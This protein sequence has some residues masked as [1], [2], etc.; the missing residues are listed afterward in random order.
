MPEKLVVRDWQKIRSWLEP[1]IQSGQVRLISLDV[2]D[3]LLARCVEPP[4]LVQHAVCRAVGKQ[5]GIAPSVVW[6]ARQHA[7]Q[8]LRAEAVAAG[9]DRNAVTSNY[10]RAGWTSFSRNTTPVSGGLCAKPNWR[11]KI[12]H[13]TS[14]PM[15]RYSWIGCANKAL[16]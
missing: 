15:R 9:F 13:Y 7:E 14:N 6:Q 11:W 2:F 8:Q 4:V 5:V 3:T 10:C 16:K 12:W 1:R